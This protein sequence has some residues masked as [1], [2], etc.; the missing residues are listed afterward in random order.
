MFICFLGQAKQA[1]Q[2]FPC[3]IVF[4]ADNETKNYNK[5]LFLNSI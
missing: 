4:A 1:P 5:L 3:D 2:C